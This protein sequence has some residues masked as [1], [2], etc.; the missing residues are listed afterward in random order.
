MKKKKETSLKDR[1]S[2]EE[3]AYLESLDS[4]TTKYLATT[5]WQDPDRFVQLSSTITELVD[6]FPSQSD[7]AA[8]PSDLNWRDLQKQSWVKYRTFGPLNASVGSKADY[9]AEAG[10]SVYSDVYEIN[11]FLNDL[12]NSYRNQLY[13][14]AVGWIIRMQAEGE[15]FLLI[16][17]DE[18]GTTTIRTLEPEYIGS[19]D[20]KGLITDPDDVTQTLF[21]KYR[22]TGT[23][24]LIPD[25]RFILEPEYM[26][27]RLKT[28]KDKVDKD[29]IDK[30]TSGGS[31]FKKIGGYRRFILH[32][33]NFT[34]ILE[35][36]RDTASLSTVLEWIN[37][38]VK[39]LKWSVDHKRAISAYT[40]CI[41]FSDTPTGKV[42]WHIWNKMT[43]TEKKAT[44]LTQPFSPGSK[45]FNMPGI[46]VNVYSPQIPSL[47][48]SNQ[49]LLNMAGAGSRTPTDLWQGD[50]AGMPYASVKATRP[51][52]IAEIEN[53]QSK[54]EKF[55]RY[56]LLR[57][58]FKAKL[59]LGGKI[60]T[61]TGKK[62]KL[63]ETYKVKWPGEI[64]KGKATF[65]EY[66]DELCNAAKFTFP[67]VKL[68]DKPEENANA[69]FGSK[70]LGLQE[71]VSD[72]TIAKKFFG[73]DDISREKRKKLIEQEEFGKKQTGSKGE[74]GI[75]EKFKD[76]GAEGGEQK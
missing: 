28:I 73:I 4:D 53:L 16:A 55:L 48:G 41:N 51:P 19:S 72:E 58:C 18:S 67:T 56:N 15:L 5:P 35:Y 69:C 66:D 13:F 40:W 1:F 31:N 47:S 50:S 14:R 45:V 25:A 43:D 38:Y 37:L 17:L 34:G 10:F 61:S 6:L 20:D 24:E 9:V 12:F 21:Y 64:V 49:D 76:K 59:A 27:E 23:E 22:G 46:D 7:N 74:K 75:E 52:L 70:H 65:V 57:I 32:W 60:I 2:K 36:L 71:I 42:A 68:D 26:N 8:K 33:K 3:W 62:I 39:V 44:G 29:K 54:F 30:L 11:L 63:P